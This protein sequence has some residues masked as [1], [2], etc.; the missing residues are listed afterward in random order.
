MVLWMLPFIEP[1]WKRR[2]EDAGFNQHIEGRVSHVQ[3][4]GQEWPMLAA[5]EHSNVRI[6]V[7]AVRAT[8]TTAKDDGL[9]HIVTAGDQGEK[10]VDCTPCL[11]VNVIHEYATVQP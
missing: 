5:Q 7:R 8:R 11:M 2:D 9:C 3:L 4:D 1:D 10:A 6:A